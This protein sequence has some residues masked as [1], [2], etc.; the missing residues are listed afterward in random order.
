MS[1]ILDKNDIVNKIEAVTSLA[2]LEKLR[3]H[4]LGKKG[5][6]TAEMKSLSTLS[7]DEKKAKGQKLNLIKT[8]LE[9]ELLDKNS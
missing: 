7:L 5:L 1:S 3:V 6:L 8:F 2:E 9:N 4:Y